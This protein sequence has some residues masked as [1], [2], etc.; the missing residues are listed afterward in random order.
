MP[1]IK[2]QKFGLFKIEAGS[3]KMVQC[4]KA[5]LFLSMNPKYKDRVDRVRIKDHQSGL[6][7][8]AP[9]G[10]IMQAAEALKTID[11]SKR[12]V[13]GFHGSYEA[14]TSKQHPGCPSCFGA[15]L[16]ES[17]KLAVQNGVFEEDDP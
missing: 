10:L 1:K 4:A 9:A 14:F 15:T 13:C 7:Y 2:E 17:V 11:P 12:F 16:D 3:E 5:T 6:S 8:E